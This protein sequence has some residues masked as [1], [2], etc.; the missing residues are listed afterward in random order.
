MP[1]YVVVGG[2]VG[3]IACVEELCR[4]LRMRAE[5]EG[6][7]PS[8]TVTLVSASATIK[9]VTHFVK[10]SDALETFD[11]EDKA[12]SSLQEEYGDGGLLKVVHGLVAAV[13]PVAHTLTVVP[14]SPSPPSAPS[15]SRTIS[16]DKL[17]V[18]TGAA[19]RLL[20][21]HPLVVG[22]RDS[23]SVQ[24]LGV[25]LRGARRV[26]LLGNGG[27]AL[28][29]APE[30]AA[31]GVELVWAVRD[32]YLGNTFFDASASEFL[33]ADPA[34]PLR[35][36]RVGE[37]EEDESPL[38][39]SS[40][41]P[42]AAAAVLDDSAVSA[43]EF[44]HADASASASSSSS[45][46]G[47]TTSSHPLAGPFGLAPLPPREGGRR[48]RG[49]PEGHVPAAAPAPPTADMDGDAVFMS[50][51]SAAPSPAPPST[52]S[53][54]YG[55]SLGPAWVQTLRQWL[56]DPSPLPVVPSPPDLIPHPPIAGGS[57][58]ALLETKAELAAI[59]GRGAAGAVG[60][61]AD[62][63]W[64]T[65]AEL[66]GETTTRGSEEAMEEA[67]AD[68]E[69]DADVGS[70]FPLQVR[71]SNGRTYD[72]DFI[73]SATGVVPVT[74]MLSGGGGPVP[75]SSSS[76]SS[77]S[78]PNTFLRHSDGGLVVNRLMQTTGSPDVYAAGDAAAVL[79]PRAAVL[80]ASGTG[81]DVNDPSA[82][83]PLW[84]QMR[85]WNQARVQ[86]GYA[87]RC[88]LDALDPLEEDG[89]GFSFELFAH[90]TRFGGHKVVLLGLYN[91]QG[92]GPEYERALKTQVV[93]QA[94]LARS[95]EGM[96]I[97][98]TGGGGGGG[99]GGAGDGGATTTTATTTSSSS[100]AA[101][102]SSILGGPG[103]P[104]HVQIRVTPGS[105]YC[106]VVLLHGRVVGALLIGDTD[107]EETMEHLIMNRLDVRR[108]RAVDGD[109]DG[110]KGDGEGGDDP[111]EPLDLLDPD[112]D[113][114][115]FFD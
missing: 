113:I 18:C 30:L 34:R 25:L 8:S 70:P 31:R 51:A 107:L 78:S 99:V 64:H 98:R 65:V 9:G 108:R 89:G 91:G 36:R 100:G 75:S 77:S 62:G 48:K 47:A 29:L 61:L 112:I 104:V 69:A 71:L 38:Q 17:C 5:D 10:V 6:T 26:V 32:A 63:R 68:A 33:L 90:M 85:L 53:S 40:A 110:G 24:E 39:S 67:E 76:S 2:G 41:A 15:Q 86:G 22:L 111:G 74:D 114:E 14:P 88:M 42:M 115:D 66:Q 58:E 97:T 96:R 27:I 87:A 50:T 37:E 81:I 3:G 44:S 1:H 49:R 105:E 56:G 79:W 21:R 73:V 84:F 93:T 46:A 16:F 82:P 109:G 23:V 43:S 12:L 95:A 52:T 55:S 54:R 94:G 59:R 103:S 35:I 106:K 102:Q 57:G 19:P 80:G 4:V 11:L 83:V 28:G 72:C 13:D 60:V 45:A 101:P 7:A 20:V 92:L